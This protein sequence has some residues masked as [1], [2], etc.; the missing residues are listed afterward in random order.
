MIPSNLLKFYVS[1]KIMKKHLQL[2][3]IIIV[4]TLLNKERA[5]A[6]VEHSYNVLKSPFLNLPSMGIAKSFNADIN[7]TDVRNVEAAK[8]INFGVN[9]IVNP[10]TNNRVDNAN[11]CSNI[12]FEQNFNNF[13][14]SFNGWFLRDVDYDIYE[15]YNY[16]WVHYLIVTNQVAV[17]LVPI[18]I[19]TPL[20]NLS[21][22]SSATLTLTASGC[23]GTV[24]WSEVATGVVLTITI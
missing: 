22:S 6:Q 24:T 18:P 19:N 17:N 3:V 8:Q 16:S 7:S 5:N 10:P 14:Y 20:A 23:E 15:P 11:V 21:V 2:L 4:A 12:L 13:W 1:K 9:T